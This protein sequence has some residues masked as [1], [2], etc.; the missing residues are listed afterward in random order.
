[1]AKFSLTT[2]LF[3]NSSALGPEPPRPLPCYTTDPTLSTSAPIERIRYILNNVRSDNRSDVKALITSKINTDFSSCDFYKK[4]KSNKDFLK[5]V[6][7]TS[8]EKYDW[9]NI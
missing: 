8:T 9:P 5:K 6:L 7:S 4:I 1:M 3:R 2:K